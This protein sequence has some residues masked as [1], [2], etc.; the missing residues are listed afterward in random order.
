MPKLQ[1][2]STNFTAGEQ[3]PRLRGRVDIAK[4]NASAEELLNCV[5]LKQGGAT[6][7]PPT[8]YIG[9]VKDSTQ[10]AR[11]IPFVFS[12]SDAYLLELGDLY[13]RVWKNGVRVETS[14]GTPFEVATTW[15]DEE[16][17][18][19]DYSQGADTMLVAHPDNPVQ[20]IRRF[21]DARWTVGDAS[22]RPGPVAEVG[23]RGTM[24]MTISNGAVGAGRTITAGA[25]FFLAADVGRRISWGGG[26]ALITA[27]GSAT[28]ATA[29]VEAAFADL[30]ANG[31]AGPAPIWVLEG[32]P[33]ASV[34]PSAATPLGAAVTLTLSAA[35][36]RS[37]VVGGVIDLNGGIVRVRSG[38]RSIT[39]AARMAARPARPPERRPP[40]DDSGVVVSV[41]IPPSRRV[42][43][44]DGHR[45]RA[46]RMRCA[47]GA[48]PRW[49]GGATVPW[50][51]GTPSRR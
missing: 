17:A 35:G 11:I 37:D 33:Q 8:K 38:T 16:L 49:T 7:R 25:A 24:T 43:G 10:T 23:D 48:S 12:R 40:P 46:L 4:Y 14:P 26:T 21:A 20:A 19:L 32:T 51:A 27:V 30:V 28:S 1:I 34:T 22:F 44:G 13:Q 2:I 3:S 9:E 47:R 5:V 15:N 45:A 6:I 50:R 36:W 29:T 31:T 39:L 42:R 41:M 18:A